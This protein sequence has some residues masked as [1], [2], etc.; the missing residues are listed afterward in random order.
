MATYATLGSEKK[1]REE[2]PPTGSTAAASKSPK[3]PGSGG[4]QHRRVRE[5]WRQSTA[6]GQ[7]RRWRGDRLVKVWWTFA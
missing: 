5:A 1:N 4:W 3:P 7:W 6:A 2:K